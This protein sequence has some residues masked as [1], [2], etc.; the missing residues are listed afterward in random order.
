MPNTITGGD[1]TERASVWERENR[2]Q[3]ESCKLKKRITQFMRLKCKNKYPGLHPSQ[4]F[5]HLR[6]VRPY[7][8]LNHFLFSFQFSSCRIAE[9][10]SANFRL[11]F[12]NNLGKY[13]NFVSFHAPHFVVEFCVCVSIFSL[14]FYFNLFSVFFLLWSCVAPAPFSNHFVCSEWSARS[15]DRS[16]VRSLA[17]SFVRETLQRWQERSCVWCSDACATVL[18]RDWM[19]GCSAIMHI[20]W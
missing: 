17:R 9:W 6:C 12:Y 1:E 4:Q 19:L 8:N 10:V 14:L 7:G 11:P 5:I 16:Y 2:S 18:Q 20:Y 15:L 3:S 13:C